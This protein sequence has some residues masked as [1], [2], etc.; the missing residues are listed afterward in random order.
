MRTTPQVSWP[1]KGPVQETLPLPGGCPARTLG[2]LASSQC[3]INP[4][5]VNLVTCRVAG[6]QDR[7]P[8]ATS[9]RTHVQRVATRW[10]LGSTEAPV[11]PQAPPRSS[12]WEPRA[13]P[14]VPGLRKGVPR[15]GQW[16]FTQVRGCRCPSDGRALGHS[17]YPRLP[18]GHTAIHWPQGGLPVGLPACPA[19]DWIARDPRSLPELC[20]VER[21]SY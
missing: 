13:G 3:C 8:P 17:L 14:A 20:A 10:R 15:L 1:V 2:R 11:H 5:A 6:P 16:G 21:A 4:C 19:L 12:G 18:P 9:M 7:R